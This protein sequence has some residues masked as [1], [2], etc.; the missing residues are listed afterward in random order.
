V[1]A[2]E[3]SSMLASMIECACKDDTVRVG[4]TTLA[5]ETIADI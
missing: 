1:S 3:S 2:C 4:P 5:P